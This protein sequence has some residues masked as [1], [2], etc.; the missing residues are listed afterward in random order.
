MYFIFNRALKAYNDVVQAIGRVRTKVL[1][2][3]LFVSID[4]GFLKKQER[5]IEYLYNNN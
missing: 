1:Q 5:T 3:D 2:I 4:K